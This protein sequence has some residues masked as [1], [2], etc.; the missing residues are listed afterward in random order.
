MKK[1]CFIAASLALVAS[2]R[3][4]GY[5]DINPAIQPNGNLLPLLD[6]R[7]DYRSIRAVY[8]KKGD[9]R[10]ADAGNIFIKE[11][12]ENIIEPTGEKKGKIKMR[13]AYENTEFNNI[14]PVV[15]SLAYIPA[16]FGFPFMCAQQTLEVEVTIQN[17]G[18]D[19]IKRYVEQAT[20]SEYGALYW[21]YRQRDVTR[22]VAAENLK[23]ALENI[24]YKINNDAAEIRSKLQ[25]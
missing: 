14:C 20:D 22:K 8:S 21:G 12:Q 11:V 24:R 23:H 1:F 4:V 2:C 13:L 15:A 19:I 9:E 17:N 25:Q 16:V 7:P 10:A 18:K 3:S 6:I 5:E